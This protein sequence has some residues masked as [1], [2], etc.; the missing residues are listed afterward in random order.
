MRI[1]LKT[2]AG[3]SLRSVKALYSAALPFLHPEVLLTV[4][5][6]LPES[7]RVAEDDSSRR[8]A[9]SVSEDAGEGLI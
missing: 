5:L 8:A 3:S 9:G 1:L 2:L 4:L 7:K 6:N